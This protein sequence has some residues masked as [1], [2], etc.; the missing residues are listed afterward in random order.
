MLQP[1]RQRNA[2]L[3]AKIRLALF[4]S[5]KGHVLFLYV[6]SPYH[7]FYNRILFPYVYTGGTSGSL[8]LGW[9]GFLFGETSIRNI[10]GL[11]H[12]CL[13]LLPKQ[14]ELRALSD[15]TELSH[16]RLLLLPDFMSQFVCKIHMSS[17]AL[18]LVARGL[19]LGET[20]SSLAPSCD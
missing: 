6:Q 12:Y 19:P 9:F 1:H 13:P 4:G 5:Y 14:G 17:S 20:E 10:P 7:P 16:C 2:N 15:K 11:S 18:C 8:D 3:F